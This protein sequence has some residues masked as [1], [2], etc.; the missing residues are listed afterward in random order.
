MHRFCET[1][2]KRCSRVPTQGVTSLG[3]VSRHAPL[4]AGSCR[5]IHKWIVGTGAIESGQYEI[6]QLV[7][8]EAMSAPQVEYSS[9]ACRVLEGTNPCIYYIVDVHKVARLFAV[10][11]NSYWFAA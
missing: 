10:P 1:S 4:I 11:E 8:G 9:V 5:S 7:D 2:G 3:D 6:P